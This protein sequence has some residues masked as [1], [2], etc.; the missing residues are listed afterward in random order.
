MLP[1][2]P[3]R[4]SYELL[5]DRSREIIDRQSRSRVKGR[6]WLIRRMLVAAD[7]VGL[8]IAFLV[9]EVSLGRNGTAAGSFGD[10]TE[11][12]LFA[13][14]VPLWI[15]GAK[16]CGLYNR[17][18]E[19]T[20]YSTTDDLIGVFVL[21]T[22]MT[23]IFARSALVGVAHPNQLR[24]TLFWAVAIPAIAVARSVAR[25]LSRRHVGYVQNTVIVGA[26]EVGQLVAR[27]ALQ[28]PE[29]GLNVIGFV[30]DEPTE[31]RDDL[32]SL[33]VL[34]SLDDLP[35]AR[36]CARRRPRD[37]CL[38][39][40]LRRGRRRRRPSARR[41]L[42]ADR[43][44]AAGSSTSSA[45]RRTSTPS[46]A[47]PW[48]A[49]RPPDSARSSMFIKRMFDL[50]VSALGLILLAPLFL[51]IGILIKL[52]SPGPIFFRQPRMGCDDEVFRIFKFRTMTTDAEERKPEL[53]HLNRHAARGG[54]PRMIKI[55]NDPRVTRLGRTLRRFSLDELPQLINV[56]TGD[57]S[58]VGPRPLILDEDLHVKD[59]A[60]R[61]IRIRPG[62]TGLWQV[63]GSSHIPF[64]EMVKL[65][66][67]YVTHWSLWLD[68]KLILRTIPAVLRPHA[69][70]L[71]MAEPTLERLH[72][73]RRPLLR[74]GSR[75]CSGESA[76]A[77]ARETSVAMSARR[78]RTSS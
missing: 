54:D 78:T 5:D 7:V 72:G 77:R 46:R 71:T 69:R 37:H 51:A 38:L 10:R 43:R 63:L 74:R 2:P 17:D 15:L 62:I 67:R 61:R 4:D 60:R 56:L 28:H 64:D 48:S 34:G 11:F 44:R 19:R 33:T 13:L 66:Y 40:V 24:L 12:L 76:G 14:L 65:D 55:P 16:L 35:R 30:D 45:R 42:R 3:P 52:D 36:A 1:P 9:A 50:V 70:G 6:G 73:A 26:G 68:L 57:M 39:P 25:T 22:L 53:A 8:G 21:V 59:W 27:K 18:E 47:C 29:Y 41:H 23:W 58:L 75:R 31:R 49:C 32:D 20:N